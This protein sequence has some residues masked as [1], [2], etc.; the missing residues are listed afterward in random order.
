M[1]W[2]AA[3][4][5]YNSDEFYDAPGCHHQTRSVLDDVTQW[6]MNIDEYELARNDFV[7]WLHRPTGT[8]KTAI[9]K[10]IAELAA[11][12]NFLLVIDF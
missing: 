5:I 10:K 2:I 3:G 4:A 8:G 1:E 7:L 6:V 9:T 11:D 12:K